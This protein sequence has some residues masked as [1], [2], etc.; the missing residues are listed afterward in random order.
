[1]PW[2]VSIVEKIKPDAAWCTGTLIAP[3]YIITAAHCFKH[4]PKQAFEVVLGSDNLS[5][6]PNNWQTYQKKFNIHKL[7]QHPN[8]YKYHFDVAI[9]E[10][11]DEVTYSEGI[12]PICLPEKPT[13]TNTR[14]RVF[15]TLAGF[16]KTGYVYTYGMYY[17]CVF[18]NCDILMFLNFRSGK[19]NQKIHFAALQIKSQTYCNDIYERRISESDLF[20]S[21][22]I[23]CAESIVSYKLVNGIDYQVIGDD[24]GSRYRLMRW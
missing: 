12:F 4:L 13:L 21:N 10:L 9:I 17:N 23:I 3:K 2:M 19:P 18:K 22:N 6:S 14:E 20:T 8:Y 7:H 16:G 5:Q 15:V 11:E 1:M 24:L